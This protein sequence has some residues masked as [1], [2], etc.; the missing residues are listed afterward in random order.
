MQKI[1]EHRSFDGFQQRFEMRSQALNSSTRFSVYLPPAAAQQRVPAVF[2]L[3]GLTCTD[4]NFVTKAG[5]QMYASRLGLALIM[6]DTSPR[7]DGVPDDPDGSYDLGLGAGFYVNATQAPWQSHYQMYSFVVEELY[8]TVIANFP[9]DGQRIGISGHSMGGHGALCLGLRN[10][11]RFGSI[12]AFAP[13]CAPSNCPW[14]QNALSAY[15]GDARDAWTVYDACALLRAQPPTQPILVDQGSADEFLAEQ[16]GT[17]N[18]VAATSGLDHVRIH[19]REGYDH[20]YFFI[21]SFIGDH[22]EF[23]A[24][25]V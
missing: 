20:S 13:I 25:N 16:L 14:G 1:A 18:L 2:W 6:P 12:S 22:L 17:E 15:L 9:I 7:G 4:E 8:E 19:M 5:A 21:A 10:P 24:A 11:E 23:H 3:S